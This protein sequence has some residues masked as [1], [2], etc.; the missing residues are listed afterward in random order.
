M[1]VCK[2]TINDLELLVKSRLEL[3]R[4]VNH[5]SEAETLVDID[6]TL[7][8]YYS[9]NLES[10]NYVAFLAFQNESKKIFMG[11]GSICFY[12]VLPTCHNPSGKKAY[13]INMYTVPKFRCQG[14]ATRILEE[15]V[16]EAFKQKVEFI[17]LEATGQGRSLYE[18][19]GFVAVTREM[20]YKNST[21]ESSLQ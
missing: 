14:V 15:L 21:Y 10:D 5:L 20:Q 13:I 2:A 11:T 18:K 8:S 1:Y 6:K 19:N 3:L 16:Q 7:R 4:E 12:C 9:K 17:T